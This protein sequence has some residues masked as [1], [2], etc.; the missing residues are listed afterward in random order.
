MMKFRMYYPLH[1]AR[2]N[3][4][5]YNYRLFHASTLHNGRS[6][7]RHFS[8]RAAGVISC[9]LGVLWIIKGLTLSV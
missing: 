3:H 2:I 6:N 4:P 5:S 7:Q 9:R 8:P 1:K